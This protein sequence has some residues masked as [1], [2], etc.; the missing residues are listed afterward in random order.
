MMLLLKIVPLFSLKPL[1]GLSAVNFIN[2]PEFAKWAI[3]VGIISII[4]FS[5]LILILPNSK[6]KITALKEYSDFESI[7]DRQKYFLLY[8]GGFLIAI[9]LVYAIFDLKKN[10]FQNYFLFFGFLFLAYYVLQHKILFF[11][12]HTSTFFIVFYL[13]FFASAVYLLINSHFEDLFLATIIILFQLAY[14][15]FKSLI[16]YWIFSI[17]T[18][19]SFIILLIAGYINL[20]L[21]VIFIL[22]FLSILIIQSIKNI[23]EAKSKEKFLFAN[24]IV[25][26]G[27]TLTIATNKKGEVVFCS[28]QIKDFLGYEKF[29][30]MG[31]N[32]WKLTEDK[33]FVGEAYH[34]NYIDNRLHIRK[35]KC[36][37][38]DYKYIQ[39][40]DKKFT[41]NLIIGIGQD[42]TNEIQIQNQ[43][44]NLV[45]NV[46]DIIYEINFDGKIK[47]TNNQ[48]EQLLGYSQ[49]ELQDSY[50]LNLVKKSHQKKIKAIYYNQ[51]GS[52]TFPTIQLPLK[53][54]AGKTVWVSQN[55]ALKK[56]DK[57]NVIGYIGTAR[58]VTL[59]RQFE[60]KD[61]K[62][63]KKVKTY[64]ETLKH[65]SSKSFNDTIN[66][67]LQEIF[68]TV[69]ITLKID[70]ISY[71]ENSEELV[72]CKHLYFK[73][74]SE[75][76]IG[77]E[78]KKKDFPIY[79]NYL[80]T[81]NLV[82]ASDVYD[83]YATQE[84]SKDYF[85]KNKVLSTL[86]SPILFNGKLLGILCIET[87]K[88]KKNW[89]I[90]DISF[91][92][93]VCDFIAI[94]TETHQRIETEKKLAYKSELLSAITQITNN[95]IL[96]KSVDKI[97]ED[98]LKTIGKATKVDRVIYYENNQNEE[99]V[100]IKYQWS[101]TELLEINNRN[102]KIYFSYNLFQ[103]YLETLKEGKYYTGIT[104]SLENNDT[105]KNLEQ[106]KI[107]SFLR[108]PICPKNQL[109]GF[110][111]FDDCSTERIWTDDEINIL[112][113]L[114]NNIVA[115]IEKNNSE[116]ILNETE[117]RFK[118]IANNIPG[119]VYLSNFDSNFTKIY[120]TNEIENLT[121][122]KR[123]DFLSKKINFTSLIHPS[124]VNVIIKEQINDILSGKK[125]HSKY[126]IIKKSGEII[127]VEEFAD[128]IKNNGNVEYVGGIFVDIT[129][130]K[131]AEDAI[132][133]K[134][135]AEAANKAKSDFL[136]NM[137][138]EIRTPLNGI[139][140]FTDLLKN[141]QLETIQKEYMHT[142]NQSANSLM[143]VINEILDFSK[144]E[145]GKMELE[146]KENDIREIANNVINLVKY[147][148]NLK[149][150]EL[151]LDIDENIPKY[152][153]VDNIRLQQVLINLLSN[154]VKFTKKGNV[155]L[156]I[157]NKKMIDVNHHLIHFSVT[158][159]GVGIKKEFLDKIF[160][161][162]SQG[163]TSTTR[164]YGGTGLGLTISNQLLSLMNSKLSVE[165]TINIGSNFYFELDV[166][167]NSSSKK[168][169][170]ETI[171]KEPS[172]KKELQQLQYKILIVE[173]NKINLLLA[174]TL[175]QKI[176]PNAEIYEATNGEKAIHQAQTILPDL[177][178]MDIQMPIMNGYEATIEIRKIPQLKDTPII[179]LTAGTIIGEKERCIE[180][181]MNDYASKPIIKEELE[182][183]LSNW[184]KK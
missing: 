155:T 125:I 55:V 116:T 163:D 114:V 45:E 118:L 37:N 172:S 144:I 67:T 31:L 92:K 17:I 83:N 57:G 147:D 127:W 51:R 64:T 99:K 49:A 161:A 4:S 102:E 154:A 75:T 100:F 110:I 96:S 93:S 184:I 139:I 35:L 157:K 53:T 136:A 65:I 90:E 54:K 78:I 143:K 70:R 169:V 175:V 76:E 18:L 63:Q 87:T 105:R 173:D 19:F 79:F 94:A 11:K 132:R 5:S 119:T 149:K 72:V 77:S 148:S 48:V 133:A 156:H 106:R 178:I 25:N 117:Q 122:Y 8:I 61:L 138:H 115:A 34:D 159:T 91:T 137:S 66:L 20:H 131:E 113:T 158:D 181:G 160:D 24:E 6:S 104:S 130:Q 52:D 86:D 81:N 16:R 97:F 60:K 39:W 89:D 108:F 164:I 177:I 103:N 36:K 128:A 109:L 46:T 167:T 73:D 29:Q 43:Y 28:D 85:L 126:R 74:K 22:S 12:K 179:A 162:F 68:E 42:V 21:C 7:N 146:I 50:F 145:S 152:L 30:I 58:D 153:F 84:L 166:K 124:D 112:T 82:S 27:N 176:S 165:S 69:A 135:Y 98:T 120:L 174:K 13:V 80:E 150:I 10:V 32:F 123:E 47:F 141:T 44:K 59:L 62:K 171:I 23:V 15:V 121:G 40:K 71:W 140:G 168:I 107:K 151:Q 88:K 170:E 134:K 9:E 33:D 183:V 2:S 3:F 101:K 142:I 26:K 129:K 56:D 180:V 38:G 111:G 182:N 41:D 1:L 95:F 14:L